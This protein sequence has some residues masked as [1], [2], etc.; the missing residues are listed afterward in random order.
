PSHRAFGAGERHTPVQGHSSLEPTRQNRRRGTVSTTAVMAFQLG[1]RPV[2]VAI[3]PSRTVPRAQPQRR[4]GHGAPVPGPGPTPVN[5]VRLV[6]HRETFVTR[7]APRRG[8]LRPPHRAP[9][10]PMGGIG[11]EAMRYRR[12]GLDRHVPQRIPTT[13]HAASPP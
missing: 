9:L 2:S 5:A 11:T 13:A 8:D 3:L 10:G 7:D 1:L 6:L 12:T 4:T